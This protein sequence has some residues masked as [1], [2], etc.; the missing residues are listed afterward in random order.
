MKDIKDREFKLEVLQCNLPVLA[1]F[2]ADWCR[3]CY[4]T[5]L[6]TEELTRLYSETVKFVRIN[7][8]KNPEISARYNITAVPTIMTFYNSQMLD[9][10][11]GFQDK[12]SLKRLL[13]NTIQSK[14]NKL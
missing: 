13:D 10:R 7:I 5:C 8:E 11:V 4:P 3:S 2:T 9:K 12:S 6:I 1:C 14:R